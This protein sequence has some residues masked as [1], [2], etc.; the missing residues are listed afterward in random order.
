MRDDRAAVEG[1]LR[2]GTLVGKW[3]SLRLRWFLPGHQGLGW[4]DPHFHGTRRRVRKAA[5]ESLR[6]G[7]VGRGE[8]GLTDV[9]REGWFRTILF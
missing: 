3:P 6:M 4:V 9:G 8:H 1:R 2:E 7:R 5:R